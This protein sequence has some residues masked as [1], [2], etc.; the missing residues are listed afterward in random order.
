MA[1]VPGPMTRFLA[2]SLAVLAFVFSACEKHPLPDQAE[3][4]EVPGID[5]AKATHGD[6]HVAPA[7]QVAGEA[8]A[9]H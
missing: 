9:K 5:G 2:L 7:K 6:D 4:K 3:V 1:S 8:P